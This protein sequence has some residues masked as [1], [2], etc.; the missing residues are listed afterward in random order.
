MLSIQQLSLS[1]APAAALATPR[2]VPRSLP[3]METV[4]RAHPSS[5]DP[6]RAPHRAP[7]R[8]S[9]PTPLASRARQVADLESLAKK[10]NPAVG[11]YD[12]LGLAQT[13][14]GE[15]GTLASEEAVIGFLRAAEIKVALGLGPRAR[16][17]AEVK[18]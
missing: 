14:M 3:K 13:G 18:L 11:F 1:Y 2:T 12:P 9:V 4:R 15:A 16:V 7:H 5:P 17:R 10:L 8:A 6:A